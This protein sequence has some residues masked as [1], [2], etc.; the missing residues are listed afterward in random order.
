MSMMISTA[1]SDNSNCID[2]AVVGATK[3]KAA[4][5]AVFS[6]EADIDVDAD[7]DRWHSH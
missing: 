5:F 1:N 7:T 3:G 6:N 4:G 2:A